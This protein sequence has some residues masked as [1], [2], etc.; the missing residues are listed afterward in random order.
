VLK[1]ALNDTPESINNISITEARNIL[2][3]LPEQLAE[4]QAAI[5]LTR[6]GKP[7]MALMS[8]ELYEAIIE[9]LEIMGDSDL[10]AALRQSIEEASEG[11]VTSWE[12]VKAELGL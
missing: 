10:M 8:W 3:K 6:R 11:K 12:T 7:V 2:T 9:T 5:A 4:E 1:M